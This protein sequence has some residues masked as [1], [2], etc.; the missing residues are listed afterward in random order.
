[1]HDTTDNALVEISLALA[2]AFFA[3]LVV[4]LFSIAAP[5]QQDIKAVA[6]DAPLRGPGPV[7]PRALREHGPGRAR[8]PA[9]GPRTVHCLAGGGGTRAGRPGQG[10][11]AD[12]GGSARPGGGEH[13]PVGAGSQGGC[14]GSERPGPCPRDTPTVGRL[15][16]WT[17]GSGPKATSSV[18]A[19]PSSLAGGDG[20]HN[21]DTDAVVRSGQPR[22]ARQMYA[23]LL[24][25]APEALNQRVERDCRGDGCRARRPREVAPSLQPGGSGW[26]AS[27]G[28][29][30][31]RQS[32]SA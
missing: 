22:G 8:Y 18:Q 23:H 17:R 4:A 14:V 28:R 2:M 26:L 24:G 11:P 13:P 19:P 32:A 9:A 6:G 12:R 31:E 21:P 5:R 16:T 7:A 10:A 20:W 1:M 30:L 27:P 15:A 3:L 29:G 25:A